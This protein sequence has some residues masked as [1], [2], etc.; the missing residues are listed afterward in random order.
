MYLFDASDKSQISTS[1]VSDIDI[2]DIDISDIGYPFVSDIDIRDVD[3]SDIR[4]HPQ[5]L[6]TFSY[7]S[8]WDIRTLC[9]GYR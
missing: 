2:R 8:L 7:L 1:Q 3:A 5:L 9:V 4:E 6:G